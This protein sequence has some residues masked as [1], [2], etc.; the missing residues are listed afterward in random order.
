MTKTEEQ[1]GRSLFKAGARPAP[2]DWEVDE[3]IELG[4]KKKKKSQELDDL[5]KSK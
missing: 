1:M 3:G 5:L 2:T 4:L